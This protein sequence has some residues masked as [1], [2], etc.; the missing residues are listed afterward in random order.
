LCDIQVIKKHTNA[1]QKYVHK[2]LAEGVVT[3]DEV[4][5]VHNR[6]QGI[7]QEEFE[8][9]KDHRVREQEW[10]S[11]VWS[12]FNS[13]AQRSRIRNTGAALQFPLCSQLYCSIFLTDVSAHS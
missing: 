2:L 5:E 4:R 1:H 8:L 3:E 12:G 7:L 9:A 6:I 10:L 13:P 11:S